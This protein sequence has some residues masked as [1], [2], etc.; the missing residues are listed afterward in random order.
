MI[1]GAES[2]LTVP[3]YS[4]LDFAVMESCSSMSVALVWGGCG[5]D[6]HAY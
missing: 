3:T 2:K 1:L 6:L 5:T 4:M